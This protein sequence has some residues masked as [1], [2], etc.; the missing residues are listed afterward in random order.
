MHTEAQ[1]SQIL[2]GTQ[3]AGGKKAPQLRY[4]DSW[5]IALGL[6]NTVCLFRNNGGHK[7]DSK[8]PGQSLHS[9]SR[10]TKVEGWDRSSYEET[11]PSLISPYIF[12]W[13]Y[14]NLLVNCKCEMWNVNCKV[15]CKFY[16]LLCIENYFHT[17]C[18]I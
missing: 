6:S 2:K 7:A 17:D 11:Y 14:G 18:L 13:I 3:W 4:F 10:V 5:L 12:L 8:A 15:L 1:R 9:K 16:T